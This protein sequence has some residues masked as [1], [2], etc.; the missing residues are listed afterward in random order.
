MIEHADQ[1]IV[2]ADISKFYHSAFVKISDTSVADCIV[3]STPPSEDF[4]REFTEM[5]LVIIQEKIES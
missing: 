4:F 1:C 5:G 3:T 2:A